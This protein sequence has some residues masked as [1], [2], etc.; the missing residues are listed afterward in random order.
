MLDVYPSDD[1]D[2]PVCLT[3]VVFVSEGKPL[4][5]SWLTT[6]LKYDKGHAPLLGSW[7]A[8]FDS[9]PD[10]FLAFY[11][12]GTFRY[13]FEPFDITRTQPKV[14]EGTYEASPT[15]LTLEIAGTKGKLNAKLLKEESK[16]KKGGFTLTLEGE[17]PEDL[18]G[19][20][21]SVP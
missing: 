21:R 18:K 13:A 2:Q 19:T 9:A 1:L 16:S 4:N 7:Y 20:F 12:D 3:D 8:G 15:R 11:F 6:K 10:R 14:L 5:G 17:I